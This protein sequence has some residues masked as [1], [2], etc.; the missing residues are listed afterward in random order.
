MAVSSEITQLQE[1]QSL[2][3]NALRTML[4]GRWCG[5]PPS[6]QAYVQALDPSLGVTCVPPYRYSDRPPEPPYYL[7]LYDPAENMP[8]QSTAWTCAAC[9]LAWLERA[10]G[11]NQDAGE[12]SAVDEIGQPE[13]INATYGLM[14]GSGAQLQHVLLETYGQST[15]Q[16]WLDFD[17]AC[18]IYSQ[19]PGMMSGGAW[20]HWVGVR[21]VDGS[22]NLW[23]ANS[24]PGY[25]SVWDVLGRAD[26]NRLGPFSC[27]WSVA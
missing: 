27:V 21:G 18:A 8:P 7:S 20:Y 19:T 15:H 14:D 12:W 25:K 26:F 24:S 22:G 23:I 6:T 17:T 2:L 13:N 3:T 4:E 5:A 10:L 9:S 16:G 1:Q 11:L